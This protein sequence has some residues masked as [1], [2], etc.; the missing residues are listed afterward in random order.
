MT[1]C[2]CPSIDTFHLTNIWYWE[3]ETVVLASKAFFQLP[4]PPPEKGMLPIAMATSI[5]AL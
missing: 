3:V 2:F 1:Q 4:H 5:A